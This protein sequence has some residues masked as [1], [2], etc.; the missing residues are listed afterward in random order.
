MYTVDLGDAQ[1]EYTC[2][3]YFHSYTFAHP[4]CISIHMFALTNG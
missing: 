3:I 4:V 2:T 1:T